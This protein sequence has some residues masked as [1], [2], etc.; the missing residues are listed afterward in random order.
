MVE[1]PGKKLI[2]FIKSA[3]KTN[4]KPK[5]GEEDCLMCE[6]DTKGGR[7]CR[8]SNIVYEITCEECKKS[9]KIARYFGET[10]FNAYT[11]GKQHLEKYLSTN[12]NTQEKSAMKQHALSQRNSLGG[13]MIKFSQ[14]NITIQEK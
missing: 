2:D 3:D 6:S 4:Q 10:H 14:R 11:R 8:K 7:K 13:Y 1:K 12:V 5:C 9:K